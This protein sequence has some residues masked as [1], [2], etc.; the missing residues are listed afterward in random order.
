MTPTKMG[1]PP[2]HGEPT[3]AIT[4]RLPASIVRALDSIDEPRSKTL[5]AILRQHIRLSDGTLL[6]DGMPL[7][8]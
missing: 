7:I 6:V 8:G 1:R 5:V 2:I 3:V 4:V